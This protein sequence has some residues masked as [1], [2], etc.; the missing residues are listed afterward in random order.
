MAIFF[1]STIKEF[2]EKYFLIHLTIDATL[3]HEGFLTKI[4]Q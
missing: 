2:V 1:N 4:L 3:A